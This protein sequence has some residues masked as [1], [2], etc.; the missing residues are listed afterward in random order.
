MTRSLIFLSALL[1][2]LVNFSAFPSHIADGVLQPDI[3]RNP[4]KTYVIAAVP[5]APYTCRLG[6]VGDYI[7]VD[8]T[9]DTAEAYICFCGVDAD[10]TT[11][12]WLKVE[13]NTADCF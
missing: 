8:D 1:L 5:T 3:G 11:Y 6:A 2:A 13:D 7:Y 4:L 9:N 12:L 10:D